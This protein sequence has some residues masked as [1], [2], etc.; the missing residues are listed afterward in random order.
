MKR[1]PTTVF[2]TAILL[3]ALAAPSS[4]M[5][6]TQSRFV[7]AEMR[8]SAVAN[9]QRFPWI[10]KRQQA[11]R[12]AAQGLIG[13]GDD[14]LWASVPGPLL[15]RTIYTTAGILYEG[16]AAY[17]PN[18]G[19]DG[20]KKGGRSFFADA[21]EPWKVKCK[22]CD[23]IYPKNDF[24]AFYQS[25]LDEHGN[26]NPQL[27]DRSLLV[28]LEDPDSKLYI[29]DGYGM[30]DAKGHTHHPIAYYTQHFVWRKMYSR[31]DAL[32]NAYQLTGESIYAHK[33][34]VLL[35]RIAD[36]YP[37]MDYLPLHK[38]GFQHSQGGSGQGRIEGCIWET[39]VTERFARAYDIIFDGI[40]GDDELVAFI[41][42]QSKQHNLGDKG[43]IAA[44]C[45]HIE[46]NLLLEALES[47]KDGRIAGNTGMT[48]TC[49]AVNAI[50]LDDPKLTEQWLD[51][52]FDPQYPGD[53]TNRKDPVSWV[54]VE[55]LDR[56]GMGGENGGYGLI[57]TNGMH[58]LADIL[59][60]YPDYTNHNLVADYPKLKQSFFV[61]SRLNVL[62]TMMPS[63]GDAGAVGSVGRMGRGSTYM[64]AYELYRDPRFAQLAMHESRAHGS[65]LR[66]PDDV[67]RADPDALIREVE[68]VAGDEP[69]ILESDHFGR[70]GQA[71][72]QTPT[73]EDGRAVYIHYGFG[74]GH[75]HYDALNIGVF[76]HHLPMLPELGYPEYT[77]AWPKRVAWT[78]NTISHNTLQIGD[79]RT[80]YSNGGHLT[81]FADAAPLRVMDVS[82]PR[83]YA[84]V[85]AYRR[86]V[87]IIDVSDTESY[88][89]DVFRARGG[90][91]HRLSWHGSSEA[92]TTEGLSLSPQDGGT[93]AGPDV[94]FAQS[95]DK[96]KASGFAYLYNV[97]RAANVTEPYTVDWACVPVR[98]SIPEGVQPHIRLHAL[99]PCDEVALATGDAPHKYLSP[100]YV[101]Q[102]R[103]GD[104]MQ[105]QFVNVLEPYDGSPYIASVRQLA[106]DADNVAAVAIELTDG[107]TDI[108]I[109]CEQPTRVTVEGVTLDG[110]FG[111]VRL[112]DGQVQRMR[113][114]G[115]T[116]LQ[117]GDVAMTSERDAY[118]GKV[119]AVDASNSEDN[120]VTLDPPLPDDAALLGRVIHFIGDEARDTSYDIRAI[121]DSG[122]STGDITL[123]GG[124]ADPRDFSAGYHYLV[125]PGDSYEVPVITEWNR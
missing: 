104:N 69:Y 63:F 68:Q 14:T 21:G 92:A 79:T 93:F 82:A 55:G 102:S 122:I 8:A 16:A 50:A 37:E 41:S 60:F 123:I 70:Y 94:A 42:Q 51:W 90:T 91:N 54:L 44:I 17:C 84:N 111:F 106:V 61:T 108:L 53:Y 39:F 96:L 32:V 43:S 72:L 112:R 20:P 117:Y 27:G 85:D 116:L 34:A 33:C 119:A 100:R 101:I 76:A 1:F 109:S 110:R 118:R 7:T 74:K 15:P 59:S 18:C 98:R 57:W 22:N 6:K 97:E 11:Y 81:L 80:A 103:L 23:E 13:I 62:D 4:I 64:Q 5:A 65:S 73:R 28:N 58:K 78:S 71:Q 48:Q 30:I 88:V 99:T 47:C 95:D 115:G 25:A 29:D 87:A 125:D 26:F 10:A 86:T 35:D 45:K 105:S 66:L 107:R 19:E 36:V 40:Q 77:G 31:I 67:F 9:A 56:D 46:Q 3:S 113:M 38:Q 2:L 120:R 114:V 12:D 124:F 89:F 121:V 52:L 83:A 49:L 75:S 24:G